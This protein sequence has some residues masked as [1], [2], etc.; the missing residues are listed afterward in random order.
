MKNR[1]IRFGGPRKQTKP[2]PNNQPIEIVSLSLDGRGIGRHQG[3]TIFVRDALPTETVKVEVESSNK[4][5]DETLATEVIQSS[6]DRITPIC[7][8]YSICGGCDLQHLHPKR[9]VDYKQQE[10]LRSLSKRAGL[11]AEIVDKPLIG[12]Q[13]SAYRRSARIGINQR[14][15]GEVLIG[16]RRR[17]SNKLADINYCEVLLPSINAFIADLRSLLSNAGRIKHIT[18][19]LIVA[20]DLGLQ[21]DLRITRSLSTELQQALVELAQQHQAHLTLSSK[22]SSTQILRS[23]IE[24][25]NFTIDHDLKIEFSAGDFVQ[26]NAEV[27]RHMIDKVLEWFAPTSSDQILDLYS[28][29]GNFT[30]PLARRAA[31]VVAIEGSNQMVER[32]LIN[33]KTNLLNNVEAFSADLSH[34][35]PSADWLKNT[36]DLIL[37]DPPRLGA[38]GVIS[39]L[40]K[41]RPRAIIYIACDP[42]SL[43]RDAASLAASGYK[44]SRICV[45]DMFA[46]T[47]HIESLALFEK[48]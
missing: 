45:A 7:Q 17:S 26:V 37:L 33:A 32:C 10:L 5:F 46:Q 27:N 44:I 34:P 48:V 42:A 21:I 19:A 35:D 41:Q 6:P 22:E 14:E 11:T 40:S 30:L 18:Q 13:F 8:H 39:V 43:V 25:K 3:K 36:Y 1:P 28:G 38:A 9:A 29:L 4:R 12:S 20:G 23:Y 16:F 47:H 15:S 31:R 2:T 24:A